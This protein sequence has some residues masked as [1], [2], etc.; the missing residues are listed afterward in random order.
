MWNWQWTIKYFKELRQILKLVHNWTICFSNA[1]LVNPVEYK[2]ESLIY[3]Q[4]IEI[5]PYTYFP[6]ER[7]SVVYFNS[8]WC[9]LQS[10]VTV[11]ACF[12]CC[13]FFVCFF[14]LFY[15]SLFKFIFNMVYYSHCIISSLKVVFREN[16]Q[17]SLK[18]VSYHDGIAGALK[19]FEG[20]FCHDI[21][22]MVST[23]QN[24]SL[25]W[26]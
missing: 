20:W 2:F 18:S 22:H 17:H 8:V 14:N 11:H 24:I 4:H 1:D 19:M 9:S 15:S 23:E 6:Y 7:T 10:L 25:F 21:T 12:F 16:N 26:Q 3:L 5:L 13:C